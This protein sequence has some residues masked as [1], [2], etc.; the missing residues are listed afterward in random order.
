MKHLSSLKRLAKPATRRAREKAAAK[1]ATKAKRRNNKPTEEELEE[2][3]AEEERKWREDVAKSKAHTGGL[4]A[5]NGSGKRGL[6]AGGEPSGAQR[7]CA[8]SY[9]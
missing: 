9:W 4:Q 7:T 2:Q 1:G 8:R 3:E 6:D 5:A